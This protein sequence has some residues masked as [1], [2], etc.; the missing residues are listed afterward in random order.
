MGQQG[1]PAHKQAGDVA[2]APQGAQVPERKL[3]GSLHH[4]RCLLGMQVLSL[5]HGSMAGM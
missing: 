4:A 5:A 1:V 2:A 3:V